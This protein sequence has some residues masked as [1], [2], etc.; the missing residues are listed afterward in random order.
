MSNVLNQ[1]ALN[2]NRQARLA[3]PQYF[4]LLLYLFVSGWISLLGALLVWMLLSN[5]YNFLANHEVQNGINNGILPLIGSLGFSL[6]FGGLGIW[7]IWI[8][9]MSSRKTVID[10]VAGK[11]IYIDGSARKHTESKTNGRGS[12]LYYSIGEKA[13]QIPASWT[14]N[15]LPEAPNVRAYYTPNSETF[16]NV[17]VLSSGGRK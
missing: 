5:M 3:P 2:S 17:E 8:A 11:V 1:G 14:W 7:L 10:L 13:F 12:V 9:W 4:T 15:A 6:I 16:L